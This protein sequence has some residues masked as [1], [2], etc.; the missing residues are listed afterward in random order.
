MTIEEAKKL[1]KVAEKE[2]GD[3]LSKLQNDTQLTVTDIHISTAEHRT[4][5]GDDVLRLITHVAVDMEV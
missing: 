2:I 3:I 4:S 5:M 1:K